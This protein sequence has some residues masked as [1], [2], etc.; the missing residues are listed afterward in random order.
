[1]GGDVAGC[2]K[3]TD[4]GK[5]WKMISE[6]LAG[7]GVFAL[8]V[9]PNNP[10]TVYA[11]TDEGLCKS[12][13]EGEHWQLLP[14]T[15]RKE[16]RITGEKN[17]ACRNVAIDPTDSNTIYA[18]NPLGKIYKSMDGGQSW[19]TVYEKTGEE[20]DKGSLRIRIGKIN[21]EA[22]GGFWSPLKQLENVAATDCIGFSLQLKGCGKK[23]DRAFL[24]LRT[25][26]GGV[27]ISKNLQDILVNTEWHEVVFS[28]D[29][30]SIDPTFAKKSP[31]KAQ[32]VPP[33]PDF[34]KL[35]RFDFVCIGSLAS[36]ELTALLKRAGIVLAASGEHPQRIE[37]VLD[38][39]KKKSLPT[40]GNAATGVLK[41]GPVYSVAVAPHDPRCIVAATQD[42]GVILSK[43]AGASWQALS[44]PQKA[45]SV[46]FAGPASQ[47]LYATFYGDGIY[48]S[49]D[50]GSTWKAITPKVDKA[51]RF[52]EI[53]ANSGNPDDVYVI[54][55]KGWSGLFFYSHDGGTTWTENSSLT[56]DLAANPTLPRDNQNGVTGI[57]NPRNLALSPVDANSLLI[58]A[59]WRPCVSRDGGQTW[60]ESSQGA[61]IS[62]ITDIR[63]SQDG[64]RTYAT[65]MDE[66]TLVSH[67]AGK[68][69][70]QLW[71]HKY[72]EKISGHNW[73]IAV[74]HI[75]GQDHLVSTCSPWWDKYTNRVIRSENGGKT[76]DIITAGLPDYIP[77][78]NTMW[79]R[80]YPRALVTDPNDPKTLYLGMDGAPDTKKNGGGIFKSVDGGVTWNQLPN[81]PPKRRVFNGLAIDPTDSNRLYWAV[82]G[83]GAG[84]YSS[85]DGGQ[86]WQRVFGKDGWIFNVMVTNDGTVYCPGTDLW[87][88]ADQGK[89]WKKL[90]QFKKDGCVIVGMAED[91]ENPQRIWIARTNWG[92]AANGGIYRTEDGGQTWQ[93]ITGNL[94]VCRQLV[95]RYN[96]VTRELWT[97]FP[98]MHKLQQ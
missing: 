29:D 3:S 66:G 71:P 92:N 5:T 46:V 63:F 50:R 94:P 78:G 26:S 48:K 14:Q 87:R 65:A 22:F 49:T 47:T 74:T 32:E 12:S 93:D 77:K 34:S 89:S 18:G 91:P 43:N 28:K 20:E 84:L 90:T 72:D 6:G 88:S 98:A 70:T 40:Y 11:S 62:C 58:A 13:D 95:L 83:A 81:Q 15:G 64:K 27:Y 96:P 42:S 24:T 4:H 44:T 60:T 45:A 54:A 57:S 59:N 39:A 35:S 86:S 31:E 68:S 80:S 1:M 7:Y 9:D 52:L 38:L 17:K 53:A 36:L 23:P 79:G 10:D 82:G 55:A 73:R 33:T 2:Y 21:G 16:L 67:D 41:P 25:E 76:F 75:D 61:D 8:A 19:N 51:V 85:D 69:W 30:F 37:T 97:G 56:V